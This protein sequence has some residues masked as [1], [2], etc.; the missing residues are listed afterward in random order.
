M[1]GQGGREAPVLDSVADL[2]PGANWM[3]R[4]TFDMFG[5]KFDGHPDLRRILTDR[6]YGGEWVYH[7]WDGSEI[8]VPVL[9][10]GADQDFYFPEELLDETAGLIPNCTYKL[11]R[12]KNHLQTIYNRQFPKDVLQFVQR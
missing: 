1:V 3:E 10:V 2:Y 5:I 4:E 8:V 9:L 12:G 7:A 6:L 11:Y